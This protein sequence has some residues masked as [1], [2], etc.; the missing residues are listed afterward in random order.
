MKL[1][2]HEKETLIQYE[3]KTDFFQDENSGVQNEIDFW[4]QFNV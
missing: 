4:K 3:N 2:K 1:S